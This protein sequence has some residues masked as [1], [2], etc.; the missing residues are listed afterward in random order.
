MPDLRTLRFVAMVV[1]PCLILVSCG[2]GRVG[3]RGESV[4]ELYTEAMKLFEDEDWLEARR[5][6]DVI[7]LQYPASEYA[8]DADFHLAQIHYEMGEYI[9]A[10]FKFSSV[11]R[12]YPR[13]DLMRRAHLQEAMCYYSLSPTF[14]RDQTYT[15][16]AILKLTE[17]QALFPGDEHAEECTRIIEELR[18]KLGR[19]EFE[20]A[21]LYTKMRLR[22]ASIV[23]YDGVIDNFD[24]TSYLEPAF[25][26]KLQ[27]LM[28][29]ERY[30]EARET[31]RLY[32]KRFPSGEL[33][34]EINDIGREV[35]E[36]LSLGEKGE[37]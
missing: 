3:T 23:Y 26:G 31:V 14:N 24:D 8:D 29:L 6:F 10:A 1:V 17:Y 27:S 18:E 4:D 36:R 33:L 35:E 12:S 22:G 28:I 21:V 7:S 11:Y 13:S 19:R 9:L 32:R 5:L 30:D 15:H 16:Q 34:D 25:L 37:K 2:S 20:T